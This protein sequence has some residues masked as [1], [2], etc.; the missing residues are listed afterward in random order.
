MAKAAAKASGNRLR[1]MLQAAATPERAAGE[2][3]YL[4]LEDRENLG[5]DSPSIHKIALEYVQR[6]GLPVDLSVIDG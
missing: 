2:A 3:K 5:V 1:E 6:F 4:K